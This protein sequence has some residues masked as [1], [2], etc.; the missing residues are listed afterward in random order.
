MTE[1]VVEVA[2]DTLDARCDLIHDPLKYLW[3]RTV[4]KRWMGEEVSAEWG[5]E[6]SHSCEPI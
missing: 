5:Y 3:S 1:Y 4:A 2:D 6:C